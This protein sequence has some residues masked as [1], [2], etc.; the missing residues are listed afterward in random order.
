M[1]APPPPPELTTGAVR[2]KSV[3]SVSAPETSSSGQPYGAAI[4]SSA[5]L[6]R[7]GVYTFKVDVE[8]TQQGSEVW[9]D[10]IFVGVVQASVGTRFDPT[11]HNAVGSSDAVVGFYSD[12]S[13]KVG[14]SNEVVSRAFIFGPSPQRIA[15]GRIGDSVMIE[16]DLNQMSITL[17]AGELRRALPLQSIPERI[18]CSLPIGKVLAATVELTTAI[19]SGYRGAVRPVIVIENSA[20]RTESNV[21]VKVNP[22]PSYAFLHLPKHPSALETSCSIPSPK[23]RLLTTVHAPCM[24]PPKGYA[25]SD[26]HPAQ[27]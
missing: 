11:V 14:A 6:Q 2:S 12:G 1:T 22:L 13:A 4:L 15:R 3:A 16:V 7:Q 8:I 24:L 9:P 23:A 5:S 19:D 10:D 18:V 21:E 27:C 26:G 20:P 17:A 25:G